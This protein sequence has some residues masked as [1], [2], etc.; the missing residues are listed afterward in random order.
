M[1]AHAII[2][3]GKNNSANLTDPA[4]GAPYASVGKLTDG[5]HTTIGGSGIYLGNGYVLTANHVGPFTS[6]TFDGS[7]YYDH[8]GATPVQVAA[9]VDMKILRLTTT[10]TVGAVS[11]YTGS[12]ELNN[13]ATI[14]GWGVGRDP[15][16][17]VNST[18][19]PWGNVA[20]SDKRWGLNV[21]KATANISHGSGSFSALVTVLGGN[22]QPNQGLGADEAAVTL[23][24]SGSGMFQFLGG[25]WHLTGLTTNVETADSSTFGQDRTNFSRGDFNYFARIS[26]YSTQINALVPEASHSL[27][28]LSSL[29]LLLRRRR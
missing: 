10:P 29:V 14:V 7:T 1:P 28:A 17:A 24:D 21:P 16:T 3:F 13:N 5:L 11:I 6:I 19:V 15:A 26:T 4:T 9:G 25:N 18:V 12:S 2:L 22:S 27:L 23:N 20:T 8:D